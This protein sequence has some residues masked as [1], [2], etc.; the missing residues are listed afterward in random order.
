MKRTSRSLKVQ[1]ETVRSLMASELVGVAGGFE[2][3]PGDQPQVSRP[4]DPG[5][6]NCPALPQ[7]P[8][9]ET[10]RRDVEHP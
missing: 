7:R 6:D 3:P 4:V 1:R 9:V 10:V 8:S 5:R 2:I